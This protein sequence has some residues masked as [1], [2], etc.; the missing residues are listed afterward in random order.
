MLWSK[1]TTVRRSGAMAVFETERRIV[2]V[3]QDEGR[4][5][6]LSVA[7]DG[8]LLREAWYGGRTKTS[9]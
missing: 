9:S 1:P 6:E 4:A 3:G 8:N 7:L 2:T 5:D